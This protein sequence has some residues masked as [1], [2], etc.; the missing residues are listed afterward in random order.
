MRK[1]ICF[2][3][4]LIILCFMVTAVAAEP[5][6]VSIG[7][8]ITFGNYEQD[9]DPDNGP[10][11]IEWIV[12]DVL[13]GKALLLSRYALEARPYHTEYVTGITW[14]NCALRGWLNDDFLNK[15]FSMEEQSFILTTIVDNSASQ[16]F[17]EWNT[18]GG[19]N[20]Q[21]K[22]FLLSCAEAERY[23]SVKSRKSDDNENVKARV[24]PT[25][26]AIK[27]GVYTDRY[28]KTEEG[29]EAGWWWL[30]SPGIDSFC[31][32]R[33][34]TYGS[35]DSMD[36]CHINGAVRPALWLDLNSDH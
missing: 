27:T 9:D 33:I 16:G 3:I 2:L 32:A 18:T 15:A 12:L 24:A 30:R 36:F 1:G 11:P 34:C 22:V 8:F 13:D 23:L 25:Q 35:I 19:N 20:T 10:E 5:Q 28:K 29:D 17:S 21:D 4:F 26:Y 7:D 14:E 31:T 6:N